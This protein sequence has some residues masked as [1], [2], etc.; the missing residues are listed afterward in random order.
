MDTT[1]YKNRDRDEIRLKELVQE[2]WRR[3]WLVCGVTAVFGALAV[4]AVWVSPKMYKASIIVSA[5][6]NAPGSQMNG[7]GSLVSQVGGLASLAGLSMGADSRKAESIAVLQSE[8]LT[9]QYIQ[10]N[11]LLPVLFARLWDVRSQRW[12]VTDARK[13]PTVW[14][15]GQFFKGI[16][17]ITTDTRTGL[18]TMSITWQ[19]P[20]VAAKWANDLVSMTNDYLRAKA[21]A[22]SE[23]NIAYLNQQASKTDVVGVKQAIYTLLQNE[24]NKEMLARGADEYALK[25]VDPAIAP[26]K[27]SSPQPVLWTLLGLFG[28]L[29]LA[30]FAIFVQLAYRKS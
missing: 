3:R 9:Q 21:I 26:E 10:Q 13:A 16:R 24:I 8:S 6:S 30:L 22:E 23:R 25:V 12:R 4:A 20:K 14:K 29:V 1:V 19:D 15:G 5:V 27:A 17:T 11:R 18:V 28:G 2:I 7:L